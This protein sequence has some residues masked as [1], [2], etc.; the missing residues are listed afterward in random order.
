M[1]PVE[2]G[3]TS[4]LSPLSIRSMLLSSL[5]GLFEWALGGLRLL[6]GEC[7]LRFRLEGGDVGDL[8]PI[9]NP[10]DVIGEVLVAMVVFVIPPNE[11]GEYLLLDLDANRGPSDADIEFEDVVENVGERLG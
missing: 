7:R 10:A 9:L 5:L 4:R 8:D 2:S 3:P 6:I 11:Y 1:A